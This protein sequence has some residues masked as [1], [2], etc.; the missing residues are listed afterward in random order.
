MNRPSVRARGPAR[1]IA[2]GGLAIVLLSCAFASTLTA[3]SPQDADGAQDTATTLTGRFRFI[4]ASE[5]GRHPFELL[6]AADVELLME[7]AEPLTPDQFLQRGLPLRTSQLATLQQRGFL[8]QEGTGFRSAFPVLRDAQGS[9]V[10]ETLATAAAAM[11]ADARSELST[12]QGSLAAARASNAFPAV[13]SWLLREAVWARLQNGGT[14][15]VGS[16]GVLGQTQQPERGWWGVLWF[17]DLGAQP[18]EFASARDGNDA[19]QLVWNRAAGELFVNRQTAA[20]SLGQLLADTLDEGRRLEH[21]ERFPGLQR[22]RLLNA[23]GTLTIPALQWVPEQQGSPAAAVENA[24]VALTASIA[25]NLPVREL[26]VQL[27]MSPTEAATVAYA[28]LQ[29]LLVEAL[30]ASGFPIQLGT[31]L[32]PDTAVAAATSGP[33]RVRLPSRGQDRSTP[34]PQLPAAGVLWVGYDGERPTYELP[35]SNRR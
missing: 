16:A 20:G 14:I 30:V 19:V 18:Y 13:C 25:A 1:G 29:P 4:G 8:I 27:R 12:L 24:I 15:D 6:E 11:S 17:S 2:I 7:L 34:T 22:Y 3:Q 21:P 31:D 5:A 26:T 9:A 33:I 23:D 10:V 35:I 32:R 28:E